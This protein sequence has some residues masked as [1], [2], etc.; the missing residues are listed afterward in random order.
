M[1]VVVQGHSTDQLATCALCIYVER[2][3]RQRQLRIHCSSALMHSLNNAHRMTAIIVFP[4]YI[5]YLIQ[6]ERLHYDTI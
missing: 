2:I 3:H 5:V 6:V 4:N 1:F